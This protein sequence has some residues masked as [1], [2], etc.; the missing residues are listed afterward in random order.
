MHYYMICQ[1]RKKEDNS[2][3]TGFC[4]EIIMSSTPWIQS[5]IKLPVTHT[6]IG[7]AKDSASQAKLARLY[8]TVPE[9]AF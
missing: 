3:N 5:D 1:S 2:A 8:N 9:Q 7:S 4:Q 6:Y